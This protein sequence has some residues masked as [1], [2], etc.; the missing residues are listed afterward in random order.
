MQHPDPVAP[1][2]APRRVEVVALVTSAGGLEAV[3]A[4]L[5]GLPDR[6]SAA[7]VVFQHLGAQGSQ[8]AEILGRRT[9]LPVSWAAEGEW[10]A[11]GEVKVCPPQARLEIMPD[12]ALHLV[13]GSPTYRDCPL[14]GLLESLADGF[15]PR[16]LATVLTGMGQDGAA[17]ARRLKDAGGTVLVQSA[18]T[19]DHPDMPARRSRTGPP[20]WSCRCTRSARSS[21]SSLPAVACRR[22][23]PRSRRSSGSSP[24]LATC[25]GWPGRW[26]GRPRCWG[27]SAAGRSSCG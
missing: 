23:A 8:L 18:D 12:G 19:A 14:D 21:A 26:T 11:P 17:G 15:G 20:P 3:S 7:V 4:V 25:G 5:R 2:P 24:G 6:F 13:R 1:D 10:L 22:R 9:R 16:A 27:P